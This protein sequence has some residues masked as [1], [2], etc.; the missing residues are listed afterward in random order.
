[1][2]RA[3]A[4]WALVKVTTGDPKSPDPISWYVSPGLWADLDRSFLIGSLQETPE[5]V[6]REATEMA[7]HQVRDFRLFDVVKRRG[8]APFEISGFSCPALA[9]AGEGL[10]E[11]ALCT[12]IWERRPHTRTALIDAHFPGDLP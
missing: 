12:K 6:R 3:F 9:V 10:L 5:L 4:E 1:M 8:V 7:L 2:S 11:S